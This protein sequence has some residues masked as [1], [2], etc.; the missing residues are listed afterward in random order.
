MNK[1]K[2]LG[3]PFMVQAPRMSVPL[4]IFRPCRIS[5]LIFILLSISHCIAPA[6]GK[7]EGRPGQGK[8]PTTVYTDMFVIDVSNI[9]GAQ[10]SFSA[11]AYIE[12]SWKDL[13]LAHN[14]PRPMKY[15][16]DKI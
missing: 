3:D 9:D 11:H 8:S 4:G 10:Q 1:L 12:L 14:N 13:R 5:G 16:P 15:S 7:K 2:P 6:H